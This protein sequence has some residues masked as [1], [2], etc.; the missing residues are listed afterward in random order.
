MARMSE[1]GA[2]DGMVTMEAVGLCDIGIGG[3]SGS[4]LVLETDGVDAADAIPLFRDSGLEAI[5][6]PELMGGHC[7]LGRN[8]IERIDRGLN[9]GSPFRSEIEVILDIMH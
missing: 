5:G 2:L 7:L 9:M 3:G 1:I 6:W 4:V 8:V